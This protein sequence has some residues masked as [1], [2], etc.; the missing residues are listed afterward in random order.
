MRRFCERWRTVGVRCPDADGCREACVFSGNSGFPELHDVPARELQSHTHYAAE[1]A[2]IF[3]LL[4]DRV[5][6]LRVGA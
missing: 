3:D 4:A 6:A 5:E 1:I 2:E